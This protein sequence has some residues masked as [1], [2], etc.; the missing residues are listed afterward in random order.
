M[1]YRDE[2]EI[3][4]LYGGPLGQTHQWSHSDYD[5]PE[6]KRCGIGTSLWD[7]MER[8]DELIEES[9]G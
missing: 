6:D 3:T 7:C 9:G 2:W 1:T 4:A 5:G 8:I